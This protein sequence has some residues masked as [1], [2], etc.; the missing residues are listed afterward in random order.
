M[1][2]Y[3]LKQEIQEDTYSRTNRRAWILKEIK[4]S[5]EVLDLIETVRNAVEQWIDGPCYK[6]L[7]AIK[8]ELSCVPI[9]DFIT[10]TITDMFICVVGENRPKTIQQVVGTGSRALEEILQDPLA[11]AKCASEILGFMCQ[12]D[13]IDIDTATYGDTEYSMVSTAFE[14]PDK[15]INRIEQTK[16][17]P[18]MI[19]QP[20]RVKRNKDFVHYTFEERMILGDRHNYHEDNIS[21]DV[22]N[23]QNQIPLK[24]DQY[25]L[26][27]TEES[28]SPLDNP[29]KIANFALV[30]QAS[31]TVYNS[32]MAE[33][34]VF[35][36]THAWDMRGRLYS[37]GY[38]VHIQSTEYKKALINFEYQEEISHEVNYA[39]V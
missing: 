10:E 3:K 29:Q 2:I 30:Q 37:R 18:P 27:T 26:A 9:K 32:I 7:Q 24:L 35:W 28:T 17:M 8:N 33:G 38:Y 5:Q 36:N 1:D 21:L 31:R 16:Y 22:I 25:V 15:V 13:L 19:A 14:L 39:T 23:T 34:N 12:F 6:S 4:N 11:Q 20:K